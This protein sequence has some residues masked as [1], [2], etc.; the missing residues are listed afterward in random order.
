M[1]TAIRTFGQYRAFLRGTTALPLI[2]AFVPVMHPRIRIATLDLPGA[3]IL[4]E[5]EM[6]DRLLTGPF[7]DMTGP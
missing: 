6:V 5:A 7:N 3:R 4:T 1:S 2:F